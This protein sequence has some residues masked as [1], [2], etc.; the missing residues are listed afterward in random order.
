MYGDF[1]KD[2]LDDLKDHYFRAFGYWSD[3]DFKKGNLY[4]WVDDAIAVTHIKVNDT[5]QDWTRQRLQSQFD[6]LNFDNG[7]HSETRVV[8]RYRLYNAAKSGDAATKKGAVETLQF[9]KEKGVL[10]A[11]RSEQGPVGELARKAFFEVMN[12]KAITDKLP[13]E[14]KAQGEG[15][16]P[17]SV[18]AVPH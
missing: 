4:R 1:E 18:R 5:P 8:L 7:P 6:N 3:E 9:M 11:L 16:G 10:M 15:A 14:L 17:G 12:P 13:E 2:S